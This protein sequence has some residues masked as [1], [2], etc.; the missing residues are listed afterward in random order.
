MRSSNN[1]G[2]QLP[3]FHFPW[4][5]EKRVFW[6]LSLESITS[7]KINHKH[8]K[9]SLSSSQLFVT[10]PHCTKNSTLNLKLL[11][12]KIS[13]SD[14]NRNC[15]LNL[16]LKLPG[17]LSIQ[18]DRGS[19]P[20]SSRILIYKLITFSLVGYVVIGYSRA[21]LQKTGYF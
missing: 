1:E 13:L 8:A 19:S 5:K 11:F 21:A 3:R 6:I 16:L 17:C 7:T 4:N 20:Y 12:S 10:S 2:L 15:L 9:G 18:L 14:S